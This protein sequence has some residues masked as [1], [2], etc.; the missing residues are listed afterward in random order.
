V[1]AN[2]HRV[3]RR[4]EGILEIGRKRRTERRDPREE[5][6]GEKIHQS[7]EP[8]TLGNRPPRIEEQTNGNGK[9]EA[10]R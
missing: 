6:D 2:S 9:K 4:A 3:N 1:A 7:G 8:G 10:S 5:R